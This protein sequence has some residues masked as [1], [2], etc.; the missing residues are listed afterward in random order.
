M[1]T[2]DIGRRRV[3]RYTGLAVAASVGVTTPVAASNFVVG[4]CAHVDYE[5]EVYANGC[6]PG[7]Q[8]GTAQAGTCGYIEQ[9]CDRFEAA[10]LSA[11]DGWVDQRALKHC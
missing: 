2:N 10:Y 8:I 3:L 9:V 5:T 7:D 11:A 4:D 6:P 1:P